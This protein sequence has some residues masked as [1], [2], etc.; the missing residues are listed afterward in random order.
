MMHLKDMNGKPVIE[1]IVNVAMASETGTGWIHYLWAEMGEF[2]PSWKSA[3]VKKVKGPDGK[4]YVL[5]SGTYDMRNEKAFMVSIVD[6][7]YQL[8]I[9]Q[10]DKAYSTL[11]DKSS[12]FFFRN[13]YVFVIDMQGKTVVDPVFPGI[14]GRDL[15]NFQDLVG[16]NVVVTMIEKLKDS[17]NAFVLYIW[18]RPGETL[19]SKKIAYIRRVTVN[20]KKLIVGSTMYIEEPIWKTF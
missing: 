13:T 4:V 2:F 5:G 3:Y 7:A 20:G 8:L 10:G 16:N 1:E 15:S 14:S 6:S 19:P 11:L 17:D 9:S 18:P 12:I